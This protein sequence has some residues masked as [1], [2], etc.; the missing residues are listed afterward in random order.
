MVVAKRHKTGLTYNNELDTFEELRGEIDS[1]DP[2]MSGGHQIKHDPQQHTDRPAPMW[3]RDKAT[4]RGL[5]LRAF[6]N[7]HSNPE[8]GE[9][10]GRWLRVI[11]LYYFMGLGQRACAEEIGISA[12]AVNNIIERIKHVRDGKR[13]NGLQRHGHRG[14][15]RKAKVN[16]R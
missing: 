14:R 10:A 3:T 4:V 6:P 8:Q 7:L 13:A 9:R 5:L 16:R 15:P 11:Q 2:F 1:H 12:K